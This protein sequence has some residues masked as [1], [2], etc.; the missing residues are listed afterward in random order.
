LIRY[1]FIFLLILISTISFAKTEVNVT[2]DSMNTTYLDGDPHLTYLDGNVVITTKDNTITAE[3]GIIDHTTNVAQLMDNILIKSK[4]YEVKAD[5]GDINYKTKIVS[6]KDNVKVEREDFNLTAN[7]MQINF[8][9]E[10]MVSV[11]DYITLNPKASM[12]YLDEKLYLKVKEL[13]KGASSTKYSIFDCIATGC[14]KDVPHYYL[15]SRSMD[16]ITDKRIVFNKTQFFFG[17]Q[18][19][20]WLDK[21][22]VPLDQRYNDERAIPKFG[23]DTQNGYFAKFAYPYNPKSEN[24]YGRLLIDGMTKR[25]FG[26]GIDQEYSTKNDLVKGNF[27]YYKQ[28]SLSGKLGDENYSLSHEQILDKFKLNLRVDG[29]TSIYDNSVDYK[30]QTL[31]G[32][33]LYSNN[34]F[35]TTF[36]YTNSL[37]NSG[38]SAR[39]ENITLENNT[40]IRKNYDFNLNL[41][42]NNY[43]SDNYES[44]KLTSSATVRGKET[45]LDW[46]VF[47]LL[48]DDLGDDKNTTYGTE[49]FPEISLS[50]D[51]TRLN[52]LKKDKFNIM[53]N[54]SYSKLILPDKSNVDRSFF[55]AYIPNYMFSFNKKL[56][57]TTNARYK[58]YVYSSDMAKFAISSNSSLKYKIDE[59]SSFN[60]DYNIQSPNGYSPVTSDNISKYNYSNLKYVYDNNNNLSMEL[61]SGYDFLMKSAPWQNLYYKL[62]WKFTDKFSTY[63]ATDFDLNDS[64]LGTIVN[65]YRYNNSERLIFDLGARYDARNSLFTSAKALVNWNIIGDYYLKAYASYDGYNKEFDYISAEL[66]KKYHCYDTSLLIKQQKGYYNDTSIMFYIKLNLFPDSDEFVSGQN[67]QAINS[68]VGDLYY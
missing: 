8:D 26:L 32:T 20:L 66:M 46:K 61:F 5:N 60:V 59:L 36:G 31:G 51:M 10:E 19:I 64:S 67:G 28:I 40:K 55:E 3:H 23:Y 1:I 16:I 57:F 38:Y 37:S 39:T 17:R 41:N 45:S 14:D 9:T 53:M 44:K 6:V 4:D 30:S 42:L 52:L 62:K 7:S 43:F 58:Q 68:D 27:G 29:N 24:L 18:Q 2:A 35:N 49:K 11:D 34:G 56:D 65:Q 48:Y 15:K 22:V 54:A 12:G 21:F 13:K 50:S 47:T 33:L 63:L 25:G